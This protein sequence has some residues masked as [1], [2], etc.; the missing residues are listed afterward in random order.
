MET[1]GLNSLHGNKSVLGPKRISGSRPV[2]APYKFAVLC[3][4]KVI[5]ACNG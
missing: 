4:R 1:G 2:Q 3:F 5:H